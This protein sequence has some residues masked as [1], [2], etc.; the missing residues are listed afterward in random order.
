MTN[1]R[2]FS[3]Q[4]LSRQA[5]SAAPPEAENEG[6]TGW[7]QDSRLRR[8]FGRANQTVTAQEA[9]RL[10]D[11]HALRRAWLAVKRAGGGAGVDGETLAAFEAELAPTAG[12]VAS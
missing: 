5:S 8:F 9:T 7:P 1:E 10:F 11:Q 4:P 2:D 3:R 6:A 12:C